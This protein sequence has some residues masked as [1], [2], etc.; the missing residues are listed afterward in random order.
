MKDITI[1]E[2]AVL[3]TKT[4]LITLRVDSNMVDDKEHL[5]E[6]AHHHLNDAADEFE[7]SPLSLADKDEVQVLEIMDEWNDY[8]D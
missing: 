3:L 4:Y 2:V 6:E 1:K 5:I 7:M 8:E